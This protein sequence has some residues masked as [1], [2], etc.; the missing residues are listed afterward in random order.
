M[1]RDDPTRVAAEVR[2]FL[3]PYAERATQQAMAAANMGAWITMGALVVSL[4][5][6]LA[7]V[8]TG[9]LSI[10]RRWREPMVEVHR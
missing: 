7:G 9:V 5:V 3:A 2:H 10:R 4:G 1:G 8:L 6:A